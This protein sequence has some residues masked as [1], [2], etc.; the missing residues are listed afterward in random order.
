MLEKI[1]AMIPLLVVVG[2]LG[3]VIGTYIT[4][5]IMDH[6]DNK[7]RHKKFMKDLEDFDKKKANDR[8]A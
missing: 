4:T 2:G 5:R 8:V 1:I 6:L 3:I 7:S